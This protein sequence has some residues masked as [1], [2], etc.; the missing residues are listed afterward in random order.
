MFFS[1]LVN[2]IID[3]N[4]KVGWKLREDDRAS[5]GLRSPL[6]APRVRLLKDAVRA[7]RVVCL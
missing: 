5:L 1:S 6:P 3:P 7:V 2:H 4:M